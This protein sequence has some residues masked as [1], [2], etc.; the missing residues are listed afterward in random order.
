MATRDQADS[1]RRAPRF[2]LTA[3]E[4]HLVQDHV[5]TLLLPA[6]FQQ[7]WNEDLD[8]G[9]F[10]ERASAA[11]DQLVLKGLVAADVPRD[12]I[13]DDLSGW[14]LE[15]LMVFLSLHMAPACVFTVSA[16]T[17]ESTLLIV[18][19]ARGGFASVLARAQSVSITGGR[20]TAADLAG[21]EFAVVPFLTLADELTGAIPSGGVVGDNGPLVTMSLADSRGG[22]EVLRVNNPD[23]L[24]ELSSRIGGNSAVLAL[25][26]LAGDLDAG[27][28][29][30]LSTDDGIPVRVISYV[31]GASGWRSVD[32]GLPAGHDDELPTPEQIVDAGTITI[33]AVTRAAIQAEVASLCAGLTLTEMAHG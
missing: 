24:D 18:A 20:G 28:E 15:S 1:G 9:K 11:L 2:L 31:R 27:F 6:R 29:L 33:A 21:V 7:R 8:A 10:A 25:S 32:V 5:P 12:P 26:G 3:D 4:L 19:S 23:L 16:W 22:I 17:R 13:P 30:R 14:L